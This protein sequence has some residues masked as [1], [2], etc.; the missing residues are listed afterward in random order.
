ML[1][2]VSIPGYELIEEIG[3]GSA[4]TVYKA[5]QISMDRLVAVKVLPPRLAEDEGFIERFYHEARAVAKLNH[6]LAIL[7]A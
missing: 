1:P 7:P 4:G 5:R 2:E 6:P 3:S